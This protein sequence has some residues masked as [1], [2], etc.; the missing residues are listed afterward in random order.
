MFTAC[1]GNFGT[2]NIF[3]GFRVGKKPVTQPSV[4]KQ[5]RYTGPKSGARMKQ[6]TVVLEYMTGT[7]AKKKRRRK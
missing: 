7:R 1:P 4:V 3:G 2:Q 5:M 6:R